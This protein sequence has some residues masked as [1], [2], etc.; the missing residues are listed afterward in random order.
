MVDVSHM[1]ASGKTTP[2]VVSNVV[3]DV[4]QVQTSTLVNSAEGFI[5]IE[6]S[7]QGTSE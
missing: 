5:T 7:S 2:L 4:G 1:G 6:N 3:N